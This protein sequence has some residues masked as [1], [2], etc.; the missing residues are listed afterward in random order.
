METMRALQEE[1]AASRAN[2]ERIQADLVASQAMS[3]ELRK[4]LQTRASDREGTDQEPVTP[5]REF[6]TLFSQEIV[7]AVLP[8]TLVGPKVTF[9]GTED[10]EAHLRPSIRR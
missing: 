7:D 8:A 10:P 5:P 1:M 3:E 2:R 9:T 6:P 4:D